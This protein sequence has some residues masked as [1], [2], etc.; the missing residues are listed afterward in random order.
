MDTARPLLDPL[1]SR[2]SDAWMQNAR[3]VG[4][5]PS[6]FFP[7][8][9]IG[10]ESARRVCVD[11]A[12]RSEC[13][14]YALDHHISHGVWGGASERERQRML[15]QRRQRSSAATRKGA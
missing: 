14:A 10:V 8:E 9:C 7:T 3:C 5:D 1:D 13:L 12:V 11:C 2:A 15:R 6:S 4:L